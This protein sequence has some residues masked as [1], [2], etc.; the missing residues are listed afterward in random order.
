MGG[1]HQRLA[2][3][4]RSEHKRQ[5]SNNWGDS[6]ICEDR[7]ASPPPHLGGM[8]QYR[9]QPC[10]PNVWPSTACYPWVIKSNGLSLNRRI[11]LTFS[12]VPNVQIV[13]DF[14][15]HDFRRPPPSPFASLETRKYAATHQGP[16]S[17]P[18]RPP[19]TSYLE[20]MDF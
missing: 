16:Q 10:W 1:G 6:R 7:R 5:I 9:V 15:S 17:I 12:T 13:L 20:R 3:S 19:H 18:L 11:A 4:R 8:S 2:H 14:V